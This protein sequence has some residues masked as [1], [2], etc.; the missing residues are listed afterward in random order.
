MDV[1]SFSEC[2]LFF[3]THPLLERVAGPQEALAPE[4][5]VPGGQGTLVTQ[6]TAGGTRE[7]GGYIAGRLRMGEEVTG[8][9]E[10]ERVRLTFTCSLFYPCFITTHHIFH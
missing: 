6:G 8:E 4:P 9:E 2:F 5:R 3:S 10:M 1:R 7:S